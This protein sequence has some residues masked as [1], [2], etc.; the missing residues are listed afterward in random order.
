MATTRAPIEVGGGVQP[1]PG[2]MEKVRV[3]NAENQNEQSKIFASTTR[4]FIKHEAEEP[5]MIT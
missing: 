5:F 3:A 1:L 2:T 4:G